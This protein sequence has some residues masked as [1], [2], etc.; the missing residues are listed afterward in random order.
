MHR[1]WERRSRRGG[2]R[3]GR[4]AS[5]PAFAPAAAFGLALALALALALLGAPGRAAAADAAA[6]LLVARGKIDVSDLERIATAL[7]TTRAWSVLGWGARDAA[8]AHAEATANLERA[9]ALIEAGEKLYYDL[10]YEEAIPRLDDAVAAL[11]GGPYP[12]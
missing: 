11:T 7:E 5:A 3:T 12:V 10:K 2:V 6:A 4:G 1:V 8:E 9:R